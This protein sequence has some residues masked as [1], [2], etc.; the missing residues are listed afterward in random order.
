MNTRFAGA[1]LAFSGVGFLLAGFLHPHGDPGQDFHQAITAML[2]APTWSTA[3]WFALVSAI[4]IAW[5]LSLLA[6]DADPPLAVAG[7]RLGMVAALF[8]AVEFAVEL[9]A[10]AELARF[11]QGAASPMIAL[12]DAMQTVGWPAFALAF[13]LL[14]IGSRWTPRWVSAIGVIG[15]AGL[16]VGGLVV[17]GMHVVALAPVFILGNGLS[18]WMT[19]AGIQ[20][21]RGNRAAP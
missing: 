3:H 12:L 13:I 18:I 9:A 6:D 20:L 11:S 19:W 2:A 1:L 7:I 8:M 15:A 4:L 21:V 16:S 14:A 10:Q 5:S 17:Q